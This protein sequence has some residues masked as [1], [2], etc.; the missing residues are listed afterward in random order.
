M[1]NK[2]RYFTD[3][4]VNSSNLVLVH[5]MGKVGSTSLTVS[6]KEQGMLP[7]HIHSFYTPLSTEMYQAYKSISYYRSPSYRF[8]YY[9]R[10]KLVHQLLQKRKK[11]KII[12]L[13]REPVS[14][15]I[16]MYFHAFQVPLMDLNKE[17][18]NRK[19]SNTNMQALQNDFLNRFNHTYGI[20]WFHKEFYKA[21]GIDVYEYPFDQEKGYGIIE[22]EQADVLMIQ[23]EKLN[24][25]ENEIAAFL[26]I[27]S[28]TLKNENMG[29][30]K[31]YHAV[32]KEFK[33]T[34]SLDSRYVEALY[35]SEFMHHF[36]SR[37]DRMRLKERYTGEA[38][39]EKTVNG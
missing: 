28:F 22:T 34:L 29:S 13:V 30:K 2:W 11:L 31:W 18:D 15:N 32:Y 20:S 17:K 38:E 3:T 39:Y 8:R 37:A 1:I 33:E 10:H 6:L 21:W 27:E 19:E 35:D 14:R 26:E 7:I 16:S 5:Q 12:S 36:Y 25:L 4:Y 24:S 9:W 23:M